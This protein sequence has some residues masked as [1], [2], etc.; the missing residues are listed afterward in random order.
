MKKGLF[1]AIAIALIGAVVYFIMMIKKNN[2]STTASTSDVAT[3]ETETKPTTL[4]GKVTE[5]FSLKL[6]SSNP[7]GS[8]TSTASGGNIST[9]S[10]SNT[11]TGDNANS[12]TGTNTNNSSGIGTN[13]GTN[14]PI[15]NGPSE[16]I[17]GFRYNGGQLLYKVYNGQSLPIGGYAFLA[18]GKVLYTAGLIYSPE[19][20]EYVDVVVP[21]QVEYNSAGVNIKL[22]LGRFQVSGTWVDVYQQNKF[23]NLSNYPNAVG[24]LIDG[25]MVYSS[26]INEGQPNEYA[27]Y[28]L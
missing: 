9:G 12:G 16:Q 24:F 25:A 19:V 6:P 23:V 21:S 3:N 10:G 2:A 7:S 1:I 26:L 20:N 27:I 4:L 14:E 22:K 8:N 28:Y 5:F 18:S 17:V 11:S 13:T 15:V